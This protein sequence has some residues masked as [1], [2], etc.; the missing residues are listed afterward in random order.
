MG[1]ARSLRPRRHGA[2][3]PRDRHG[4]LAH[5][6]GARKAPQGPGRESH[7]TK[8]GPR[9]LHNKLRGPKRSRRRPTLP[10]DLSSSTIGSKE[11]NFRVREG[12][13]CDLLDI[14]T[15]NGGCVSFVTRS[16]HE[17]AS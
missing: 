15:G 12:I 11:L 17:R 3:A 16:K 5:G 8:K 14:T 6:R 1:E 9:S 13:G 4:A 10:L 7:K 2:K